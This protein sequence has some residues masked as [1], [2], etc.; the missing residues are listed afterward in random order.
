MKQLCLRLKLP[1]NRKKIRY[2]VPNLNLPKSDK[3][4]NAVL[5]RRKKN[6]LD[7]RRT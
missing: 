1:L 7:S 3:K 6:L 5:Q 4:L 2:F